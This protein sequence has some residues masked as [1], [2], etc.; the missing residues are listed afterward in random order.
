MENMSNDNR[1]YEWRR[2]AANGLLAAAAMALLTWLCLWARLNLSTAALA[3]LLLIVLIASRRDGG[4]AIVL[5][6]AAAGCLGYFFATSNS[7]R[8][9]EDRSEGVQVIAFLATALVTAIALGRSRRRAEDA[10]SARNAL[11]AA[12]RESQIFSDQLRIVIDTIPAMVWAARLDGS[13]E[14]LNQRWLEYTGLSRDQALDWG[15]TAAIHPDDIDSLQ[16]SWSAMLASGAAGEVEA[17]MRRA[18]GE[19]R[20]YL[21]RAVPLRDRSGRIVKWCG[22]NTDIEHRRQAEVA[23]RAAIDSIPA[24][25]WISLPGGANDFHNQRLRSYTHLSPEEMRGDGWQKMLHPGDLAANVDKWRVAVTTGAS[26]E[27]EGRLRRFDGEYRWFLTRAEPLRDERGNIVKWYG[28]NIDI[29]DRKQMEQALRGNEQRLRDYAETASDWFW[30][31][32]P[33]HRFTHVTDRLTVVDMDPAPTIGRRRWDLAVGIEDEPEKWCRHKATLDD[34]QP[35]R[36]FT[37]TIASNDGS[38]RYVSVSGKPVFDDKGRFMGY[39]G[40]GTDVT[41]AIRA[42]QAEKALRQAQTELSHV[43]RVTTLGGLAASIA[44]EVNQ[45]LSAIVANGQAT[46]MWLAGE[47]P[48]WHEA[49]CSVERIIGDAHR[50]SA[51]IRRTREL[52]RRSKPEPQS[53]DVN[54]LLDDAMSLVRREAIGNQ[55]SLR[56]DLASGLPAVRGDRVQLQ[57]VIIN[58]VINGIEAMAT[59]TGTQRELLIQSKWHDRDQVLIAVQDHGAGIDPENAEKV[60]NAFFT[61]KPTGMGMGLSICRSI[62]EAH[63]GRLWAASNVGPGTTVQFTLRTD[64]EMVS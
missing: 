54:C 13:A 7:T 42:D 29:D 43:T 38:A 53:L 37:Y 8:W 51:V 2:F 50:A 56:L 23:L 15:W 17:R 9:I 62:I 58:L 31:S 4:A 3:Y 21:F 60:F 12:F 30:E 61:T 40:V 27:S 28:T 34:H 44:H 11:E 55:V 41:A 20:W 14:F 36:G 19:Y 52:S 63:G 57:Q 25:V 18:D 10:G 32:G 16:D 24:L 26:F 49:R 48:D 59:V 33:D 46:L 35:F 47:A 5:S 1:T 22:T 64:R 6:V 39:R 45:P